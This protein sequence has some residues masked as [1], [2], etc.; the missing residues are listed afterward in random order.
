M[1]AK[2]TEQQS[3]GNDRCFC[4]GT[5][6]RCEPT[7]RAASP[8]DTWVCPECTETWEAFSPHEVYPAGHIVLKHLPAD[9]LGWR[10][11]S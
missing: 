5:V 10:A 3:C 6:H 4:C 8:G 9:A 1:S 11:T 2:S 7:R